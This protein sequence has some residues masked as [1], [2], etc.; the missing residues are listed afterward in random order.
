MATLQLVDLRKRYPGGHADAVR[1]VSCTVD[2]GETLTVLGPSGSGKSTL[3]RLIA[4]LE[5]PDAGDILIGGQRVTDLDPRARNVAMV[6]QSY[7]LYPHMTAYENI[8]VPLRLRGVSKD[9]TRERV[10]R[11]ADR[12]RI[13]PLLDRRPAALSGGERQRVALARALVREPALFLLDEPL[14]NLDALLREHAR[15][16]LKALFASLAVPVVYVTHDQLE[17]MTLSTRVAVF[18]AGRIEQIGTPAEIYARPATLFVARFV[19]SPQMNLLPGTLLP[20]G[21]ATIGFRPEDVRIEPQGALA[22]RVTL[23][24]P[25]GPQHLL[26]LTGAAP[27]GHPLTLRALVPAGWQGGPEVRVTLDPA[28]A[29]GFDAQERRQ[30]PA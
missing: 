26:T 11:I 12:L 24:E 8:A 21:A 9:R 14:S 5:H 29:H 28:R 2:D 23:D 30:P 13:A 27:D 4:G 18:N 19:G 3:L 25:L 17:A 7:A 20:G 6:F 15:A 10:G 16:E 22:M 1:G